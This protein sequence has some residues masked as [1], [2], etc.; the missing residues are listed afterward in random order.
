MFKVNSDSN[1]SCYVLDFQPNPCVKCTSTFKGSF[2]A[3]EEPFKDPV[4]IGYWIPVAAITKCHRFNT[5][6]SI[7]EL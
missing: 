3:K 4:I 7:L 2:K 6:L 1:F 5:N